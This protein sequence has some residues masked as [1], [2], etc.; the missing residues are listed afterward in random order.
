MQVHQLKKN[1]TF[2]AKKRV[3]RGGKK[4]TYCGAGGKGQ[5]GRSGAR[6]KP[7]VREWLKKYPK[8]RGYNFNTQTEVSVINLSELETFFQAKEVISPAILVEKR[9]IRRVD[10]KIPTV[11]VLGRGDVTKSFVIEGCV[12]SAKAKE[13]LEKAGSTIKE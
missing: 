4:G 7:I 9:I 11:K 1:S 2:K 5:K 13:K 6:F 10:G 8:L 12:V 3:G